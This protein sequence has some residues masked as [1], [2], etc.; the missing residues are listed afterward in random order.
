MDQTE[1]LEHWDQYVDRRSLPYYT[2]QH[3]T[4]MRQ[5]L[6]R[7]PFRKLEDLTDLDLL[8]CVNTS[9]KRFDNEDGSDKKPKTT[10]SFRYFIGHFDT[11]LEKFD[12][13]RSS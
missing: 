4:M 8:N 9:K 3:K 5:I 6:N 12:L 13:E 1:L 10:R 7:Y 11:F 2:D